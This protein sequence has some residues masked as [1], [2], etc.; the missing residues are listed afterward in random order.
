M[1]TYRGLFLV[2][3]YD[4][5]FLFHFPFMYMWN[6]FYVVLYASWIEFTITE[7]VYDYDYF[8]LFCKMIFA[9]FYQW[10]T[11]FQVD[12]KCSISF[13]FY[14]FEINFICNIY[15][16][17]KQISEWTINS[18]FQLSWNICH[19]VNRSSSPCCCH[20]MI[21]LVQSFSPL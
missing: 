8:F 4:T 10:K 16:S 11:N 12:N 13:S 9:N 17:D 19:V 6:G 7:T 18:Y 1:N 2:P 5:S 20:K 14:Y 21:K 3:R 15:T